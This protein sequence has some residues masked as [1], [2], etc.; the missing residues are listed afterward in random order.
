MPYI[1][2]TTDQVRRMLDVVG[3]DSMEALF[4]NIPASMRPKSFDLPEGLSED[5]VLNKLSAIADM[6]ETGKASFLGAGFYDH[7]QPR[8]V[9]ALVSRSE[10][11]TAYTPYQAEASQGTLQAIFEF[12]TAIC[13]LFEMDCANASAYDGGTAIFEACM[14]AIRKTKRSKIII[15]EAL[16]PIYRRMLDTMTSSLDIEAVIVPHAN[17]TSDKAALAAAI[18]KDT[19]A[20]VVQNPNFFGVVEDFSDLAAVARENKALTIM[21]V[22]PVLASVLKTPGSMGADIVV[23]EGQSLGL[24]LS[25][26]GPYLGLMTCTKALVRQ[27]PGR[28][29]GRTEDKQG[30]TGYVLTLQA[31]EQHIRRAKAT[32]NICSNQALCALMAH[33]QMCMLGPVGLRRQAVL[34]MELARYAQAR[35]TAVHGVEM[36]NDAPYGNEFAITLPL[37][38]DKVVAALAQQGVA[39]GFPLGRYY[40]GLENALL[41]A[42]TDKNTA[43]QIDRLAA[44]LKEAL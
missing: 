20:V 25:F 7:F 22:Y 27:L 18:D 33:V 40:K 26:G 2:H 5:A 1:P 34:S 9:R 8:A 42:T 44:G 24:P 6:N 31:R 41:V 4:E 38:A 15:D 43:E 29:A 10:F 36:L 12:Q 35:L 39:A 23:G 3:V 28:I 32:S 19:A 21:S 17:G 11:Y 16:S 13:R 30:R 14:M 37:P